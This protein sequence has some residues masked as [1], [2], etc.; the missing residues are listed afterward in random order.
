M[1]P[2]AHGGTLTTQTLNSDHQMT[3]EDIKAMFGSFGG[4]VAVTIVKDQLNRSKGF[5][6]VEVRSF[7]SISCCQPFPAWPR[8][9][10]RPIDPL[11]CPRHP[12]HPTTTTDGSEGGGRGGH[13]GAGREGD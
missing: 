11:T 12:I 2:L 5:G 8:P 10:N 3:E 4:V 9:T 6:F 13:R 1:Y 7:I